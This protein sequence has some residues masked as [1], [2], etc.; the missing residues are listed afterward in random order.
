MPQPAAR[1]RR[2]LLGCKVA[3][4]LGRGD[5]VGA[6][7]IDEE[8]CVIGVGFGAESVVSGVEAGKE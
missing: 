1:L 7:V 6:K 5:V 2:S 4:V 3:G 8:A